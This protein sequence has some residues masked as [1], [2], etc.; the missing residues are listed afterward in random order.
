MVSVY[1]TSVVRVG[2]GV[3]SAITV[4]VYGTNGLVSIASK[5][6]FGI[7][8]NRPRG[9]ETQK[10]LERPGLLGLTVRYSAAGLALTVRYSA[11]ELGV[12][13]ALQCGWGWG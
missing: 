12:D 10:P 9:A 1:G 6:R 13:S 8:L 11:V 4:R 7:Q 5:P 2:V 3:N